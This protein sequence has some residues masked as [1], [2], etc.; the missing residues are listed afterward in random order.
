MDGW[1]DGRMIG[2]M[3]GWME[4][5]EE[6]LLVGSPKANSGAKQPGVKNGGAIFRCSVE[7]PLCSEIFLDRKGNDKR[8][9]G[10]HLLQIEE[11][12]GQMLGATVKV[13]KKAILLWLVCAPHYKYFFSKFEVV[14]PVGTCFYATNGFENI[15]EFSSCRQEP[16]RHGHHRFGY[17]MCG[18]SASIPDV[19]NERLFI[20]APGAYYWQGTIFSQNIRNQSI[21]PNTHDGPAHHDN[22][23]LGYSLATGDFDGDGLDDVVAGVPRGNDLVGAVYIFNYKLISLKNLT[24]KNGQKGQFLVL[25]YD[26]IIVG[27][28]F[29]TDYK[30]VMDVKTQEHKPRYDIGKVMIFFQGTNHDFPKWESLLGHTEWSRFGYSIA[31]SGDLNQDGYNDFIVGAPYDGDD[32]RGAVYVYH[33]AKNGVPR[34]VSADLK[35][36]GFSLTGGKD[37]DKN[38]YPDIAVGA[39]QSAHAVVFKTKPVVTVTGSL[40]TAKRSINLE[41]KTCSTEFGK[42]ACEHMKLCMK[43]EGK[44]QSP[45]DIDLKLLLQ[46]DSKKLSHH[47]H[48]SDDSNKRNTKIHKKAASRDQPDIIEQMIHLRKGHEY[49]DTY[50]IYVSDSIRD[51]LSPIHIIANYSYEERTSGISTSGHLEPALDTTV[52]L[53]FEVELPIDKNCGP[54]EKCIPDLQVHVVSNK[55]KFTVGATDQSLIINVTVANHGED[56][57]ESQFLSQYHQA[58]NTVRPLSCSPQSKVGRD[59]E[60]VFVCDIGN[61]LSSNSEAKFGFRLTGTK[62]DAANEAIE[63]KMSVNSSNEE[64]FGHDVDNSLI[65]RVP[66]EIKAQ[67]SLVGRSTPEQLDYSIRNRTPSDPIFDSEIGPVVSHL[68]QVINRGPSAISGASLDIIWP[69]FAEDGKHLL[70]LIDEPQVNDADKV[71]CRVKQAENINPDSLTIS[72]EHIPTPSAIIY[73]EQMPVQ[74][75]EREEQIRDINDDYKLRRRRMQTQTQN[76]IR[77]QKTKRSHQQMLTDKR[78]T[79]VIQ[80]KDNMKQA[81]RL[82]KAAGKAIEYRG[83]LNRANIGCNKDNCTHI[84]CDIRRLNEDEFVLVEIYARL[85]VNTLIDNN[86]YEADISS[87]G[88]AKISALPSVPRYNPPAQLVAVTTDVNPTD[89]EQAQHGVPWWL[90]LIAVLIGLVILALLILCLWRCGFFKRNRPPTEQATYNTNTKNTDMYADNQV[91]FAH[92]H[93]YSEERHGVRSISSKL[94]GR[95]RTSIIT[96]YRRNCLQIN[97]LLPYYTLVATLPFC[98]TQC[99]TC[100]KDFISSSKLIMHNRIHTAVKPYKCDVCGQSFTQQC[101]LKSHSLIH[102]GVKP[103]KCDVCDQS[104]NLQGN[105]NRHSLIHTGV[106]PYKCDVCNKQFS[107]RTGLT[108]HYRV[109]TGVKPFKYAVRSD[110]LTIH[111]RTHTDVKHFECHVCGKSFNQRANLNR[112]SLIHIGVKPHKCDACNK[113][114]SDRRSLTKHYQIHTSKKLFERDVCGKNFTQPLQ[115][116]KHKNHASSVLIAQNSVEIIIC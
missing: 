12:S 42:M 57:H 21:R 46:L 28:P 81:V 73:D 69:S 107:K 99:E 84:E 102:T 18:F 5:M 97:M 45:P 55:K 37:I 1:M 63:V 62:V 58:L 39:Y 104:F 111:D 80:A 64:A 30:T 76:I 95:I 51:K 25:L 68:Y 16:A 4:E 23:N 114:F 11:K 100:G 115:L 70:Y 85:V 106:K 2:W 67:L 61:P 82:A 35:A 7:K 78:R 27:S 92:P 74:N 14:E 87:I 43:Y 91:R 112:H 54:D 65:V 94:P 101:N 47:E 90:Y 75:Y 52:P 40:T 59:D 6:I 24:D 98:I 49:C 36:F 116:N 88:M 53:A 34:K 22:Y 20:G 89:P 108:G 41:D 103:Y 72:N 44:G 15:E 83:P 3:D 19:G 38:Q 113:E 17:G 77:R 48:F 29:Y 26:D 50:D 79:R 105:L 32:H 110:Q 86:I 13:S 71:K 93:M 96:I 56:S 9:N 31:A 60:Y 66:I 109:H 10:S 33:G 8:L